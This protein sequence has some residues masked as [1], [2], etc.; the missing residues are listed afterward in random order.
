MNSAAVPVAGKGDL[1]SFD[2]LGTVEQ[3]QVQTL[4]IGVTDVVAL[5]Q[6][7]HRELLRRPLP[8]DHVECCF[9]A[10]VSAGQGQLGADF[11]TGEFVTGLHQFAGAL[12]QQQ[13]VRSAED[14]AVEDAGAKTLGDI[15]VV[16]RRFVRHV[17][18]VEIGSSSHRSPDR[19]VRPRIDSVVAFQGLLGAPHADQWHES[20]VEKVPRYFPKKGQRVTFVEGVGRRIDEEWR[21]FRHPHGLAGG[22]LIPIGVIGANHPLERLVTLRDQTRLVAERL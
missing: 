16:V 21:D 19:R 8:V 9:Q 2:V 5:E 14:L 7:A 4:D 22:G 11:V 12:Q 17:G 10:Q 3:R 13:V 20:A 1:Q 6:S 18:Q 15:Q